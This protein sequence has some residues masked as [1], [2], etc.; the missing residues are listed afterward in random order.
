MSSRS[1]VSGFL[2]FVC[3]A[4]LF[5]SCKDAEVDLRFVPDNKA[6]Y[7]LSYE[8]TG[9][10]LI[11]G[12]AQTHSVSYIWDLQTSNDSAAT[13]INATYKRFKA[14]MHSTDDSLFVDSDHP[15]AD[16][17]GRNDVKLMA[18]WIWQSVKGLSFN[19]RM[20]NLG[21]IEDVGS[22]TPLLTE[23]TKKVLKDSALA[24]T[25]RFS[26]VWDIAASQFSAINIQDLIRQVFPEF[27]GR[28][29]K[30]G[31]T[32]NRT[33]K[34]NIG[35]PL[36]VVQI[37]KVSEITDNNVSLLMGGSGFLEENATYSLK[38][39]Q[40]GKIIV[41]RKTGVM[42]SAYVEEVITG[43]ADN[44]PFKQSGTIKATCRKIN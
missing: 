39:E 15:V 21:K 20:N 27:P 43:T 9:S 4:I 23:L 10:G 38:A 42:E 31:D 44:Q 28:S 30:A 2:A 11:S 41:N 37:F 25:E 40:Q 16:S 26:A 29:L 13:N 8:G 6:V 18:P 17:I 33:Y 3:A 1:S 35:L 24:K 5:G 14:S 22:F 19:Y 12:K 36:V 32:I 34:Y 7:E